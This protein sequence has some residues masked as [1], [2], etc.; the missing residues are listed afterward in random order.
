MAA[1]RITQQLRKRAL[2]ILVTLWVGEG[3][4]GRREEVREGENDRKKG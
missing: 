4:N 1:A 3:E 2:D